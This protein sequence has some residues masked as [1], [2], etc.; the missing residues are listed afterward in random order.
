MSVVKL[1]LFF[2]FFS[3]FFLAKQQSQ[4]SSLALT[5]GQGVLFPLPLAAY[6]NLEE[7]KQ[8]YSSLRLHLAKISVLSSSHHIRILIY[9]IWLWILKPSVPFK[10]LFKFKAP[11][12]PPPQPPNPSFPLMKAAQERGYET[13]PNVPTQVSPS[14]PA[15]LFSKSW[16][17]FWCIRC[18]R[19][20]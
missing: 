11:P 8:K 5:S 16:G 12:P 18:V 15:P 19:N 7:Q 3:Y 9:S 6:V 13:S 20:N 1:D 2:L 10:I 17:I 4:C 14:L